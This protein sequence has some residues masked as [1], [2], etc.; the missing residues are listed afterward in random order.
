[1]LNLLDSELLMQRMDPNTSAV[2]DSAENGSEYFNSRGFCRKP[3]QLSTTLEIRQ[4]TPYS[5]PYCGKHATEAVLKTSLAPS[6]RK[7]VMAKAS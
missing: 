5:T 3:K 6:N 4:V 1:M 7:V 2:E